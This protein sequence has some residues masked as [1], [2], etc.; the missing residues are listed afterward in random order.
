MAIIDHVVESLCATLITCIQYSGQQTGSLLNPVIHVF[1]DR[2]E[3]TV[4]GHWEKQD[5][6]GN[7]IFIIQGARF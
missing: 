2:E 3:F 5:G 1:T 7:S 6:S 4:N